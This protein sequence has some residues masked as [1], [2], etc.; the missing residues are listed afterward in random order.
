MNVPAY[1]VAS[2]EELPSDDSVRFGLVDLAR[3]FKV[4]HPRLHRY[5]ESMFPEASAGYGFRYRVSEET[6]IKLGVLVAFSQLIGPRADN[7]LFIFAKEV[8]QYLHVDAPF[9]A[10]RRDGTFIS[11]H[12]LDPFPHSPFVI[13]NVEQIRRQLALPVIA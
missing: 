13:I 8:R 7:L 12:S 10:T 3:R 1:E 6:A 2:T 9:F 5:F 4:G 11:R